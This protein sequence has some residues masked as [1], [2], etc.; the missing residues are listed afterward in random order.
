MRNI[1]S[2]SGG[3]DPELN[4][5]RHAA[6]MLGESLGGAPVATLDGHPVFELLAAFDQPR[7]QVRDREAVLADHRAHLGLA[8]DAFLWESQSVVRVKFARQTRFAI[9][10]Q[11]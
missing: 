1:G 10:E 5:I 7:R 4:D 6:E 8:H 9:P 3:S 11:R 2:I